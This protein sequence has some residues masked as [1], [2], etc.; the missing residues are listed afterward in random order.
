MEK[1]K[2]IHCD[3]KPENILLTHENKL[4]ICVIDFGS[5]CYE[6]ERIYT[7]IQSRFY[8]SPEVMLGIPYGYPIDMWS[9]GCILVE[10]LTGIPLFANSELF[11]GFLYLYATYGLA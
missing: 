2:I 3:L 8:R 5:S 6:H 4:P 10:M 11:F 9:F 1:H 7:Y